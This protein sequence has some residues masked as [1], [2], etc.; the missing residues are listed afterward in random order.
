MCRSYDSLCRKSSG[1]VGMIHTVVFLPCSCLITYVCNDVVVLR[2]S[3]L[4]VGKK[5]TEKICR[6]L[7]S[8]WNELNWIQQGRKA[9]NSNNWLK[10]LYSPLLVHSPQ[11]EVIISGATLI[12]IMMMNIYTVIFIESIQIHINTALETCKLTKIQTFQFENCC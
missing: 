6:T 10:R 12:I 8:I 9:T 7:L 4:S 11:D 3:K 1:R 5:V 2:N